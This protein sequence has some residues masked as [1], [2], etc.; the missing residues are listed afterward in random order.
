LLPF[1]DRA[2]PDSIPPVMARLAFVF[3]GQ[4][5]QKV[6]MGA[7]LLESDA[8][9]YTRHLDRADE[10]SGLEVRRLS[11]EGPAESLTETQVAQPALFSLALALHEVAREIGL[12]A[13]FVAGHSLGEYTAAAAAGAIDPEDAIRIV[14]ERGRLMGEMQ[15]KRP[16]AMAAVIGLAPEKVVELCEEASAAGVVAPAN[17]NSPAQIVV[18]GEEAA[19][20]RLVEL[21][22][23]AEAKRALRLQVGAAFHSEL[24]TPVQD[25]LRDMMAGVQWSDVD[26]PMAANASGELVSSGDD[27]RDALVAQI[28]SPVRWIDCVQALRGAGVTTFLEIG[29]GRVLGGLVRQIDADAETFAADSRAKLEEFADAHSEFVSG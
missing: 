16:G 1:V 25:E 20:D 17:L 21:A 10:A 4:G 19:V 6:G 12:R 18:S 8:D 15:S 26:T 27:I 24:M 7:E 22:Q 5:S 3:P 9:L 14:S 13:D 29:P 2:A 28:A 23:A 11:L